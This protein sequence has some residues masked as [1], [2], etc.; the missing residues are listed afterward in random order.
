MMRRTP[1][2]FTHRRLAKCRD[3]LGVW[4]IRPARHSV[5]L[6]SSR[7]GLYLLSTG[8]KGA[9]WENITKRVS[10]CFGDADAWSNGNLVRAETV[11]CEPETRSLRGE[12]AAVVAGAGDAEGLGEAAGSTR[13]FEEI[14]WLS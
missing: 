14:A 2:S 10:G 7:P 3:G 6:K 12:V 4:P 9:V 1:A 8:D 13:E 5:H 11:V